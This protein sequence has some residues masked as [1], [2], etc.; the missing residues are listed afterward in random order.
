MNELKRFIEEYEDQ[1]NGSMSFPSWLKNVNRLETVSNWYQRQMEEENSF[2]E[3]QKK[4]FL[5]SE[6][7]KKHN[8]EKELKKQKLV[9]MIKKRKELEK[10]LEEQEKKI[11]ENEKKTVAEIFESLQKDKNEIEKVISKGC[12]PNGLNENGDHPLH[13]IVERDDTIEILEILFKSKYFPN[14]NAQNKNQQTILHLSCKKGMPNLMGY[15]FEKG[16][17]PNIE[18]LDGNTCVHLLSKL[19]KEMP[20]SSF[21]EDCF[22]QSLEYGGDIEKKN[23]A[24]LYPNQ[25]TNNYKIERMIMKHKFDLNDEILGGDLEIGLSWKNRNDLDVHCICPCNTKIY[26]SN[27]VCERCNG[28]L[29]FD[30]NV[31]MSDDVKISSNCPIEHIAWPK[32]IPGKYQILTNFYSNHTNIELKSEYMI[33]VYL[34]GK[35]IFRIKGVLESQNE[36]H[37]VIHFEIKENQEIFF[38]D[39]KRKEVKIKEDEILKYKED[40][41]FNDV[42]IQMNETN[43]INSNLNCGL[44]DNIINEVKV[45]KIEE[46]TTKQSLAE[47]KSNIDHSIKQECTEIISKMNPKEIT[48]LFNINQEIQKIE[49]SKNIMTDNTDQLN[50]VLF[51]DIDNSQSQ[52]IE[53]E[54][55]EFCIEKLDKDIQD[56]FNGIELNQERAQYKIEKMEKIINFYRNNEINLPELEKCFKINYSEW[57]EKDISNFNKDSLTKFKKL[58]KYQD[59]QKNFIRLNPSLK[60]EKFSIVE[61][62]VLNIIFK[63]WINDERLFEEEMKDLIQT[64]FKI[65]FKENFQWDLIPKWKKQKEKLM[66]FSNFTEK[67][68]IL[69]SYYQFKCEHIKSEIYL[70]MNFK[71]IEE[72]KFNLESL[73][74][75]FENWKNQ[76]CEIKEIENDIFQ[77]EVEFINYI[78]EYIHQEEF[79]LFQYI[80]EIA[81]DQANINGESIES[82]QIEAL[83]DVLKNNLFQKEVDSLKKCFQKEMKERFNWEMVPNWKKKKDFLETILNSNKM[84]QLIKEIIESSQ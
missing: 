73:I 31:R 44:K 60:K 80:Y 14:I 77:T 79:E 74:N 3:H 13:V 18:D 53:L 64:Q 37:S 84:D 40:N 19:S 30:M 81:Y 54:N 71:N 38:Y 70:K 66:K 61:E 4:V 34:K 17:N 6:G 72:V 41:I 55:T 82:N 57:K 76:D 2:R 59:F 26:F 52:S 8:Q 7:Y 78:N 29:D 42:S 49:E 48:S 21:I 10:I 58:K 83:K 45:I 5:E 22:S 16:A 56:I 68:S 47:T 11:T 23:K 20:L 69:S 62:K 65:N 32:I 75:L 25:L 50:T 15:L 24:G 63:D 39:N 43:P 27:K 51:E 33:C 36:T 12:Y 67:V 1:T 28:F 46:K 35:N 9:E